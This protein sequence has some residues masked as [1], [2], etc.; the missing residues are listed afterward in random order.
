MFILSPSQVANGAFRTGIHLGNI[1]QSPPPPPQVRVF[2]SPK[3]TELR[4]FSS[5]H[6]VL[7]YVSTG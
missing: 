4:E 7:L 2:V 5:P 6:M 3:K 1:F